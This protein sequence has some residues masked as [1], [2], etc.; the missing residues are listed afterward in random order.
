MVRTTF[1]SRSFA[2]GFF[3]IVRRR[4]FPDR[5]PDGPFT[6]VRITITQIFAQ[7]FLTIVPARANTIAR[8][9]VREPA[10][11]LR[12]RTMVRTFV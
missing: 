10:A 6:I 11:N 8:T 7:R 4:F 3:P 12:E 5:S 9:I 2:R 1:L